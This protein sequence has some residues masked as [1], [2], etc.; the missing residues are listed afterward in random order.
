MS[1]DF[2]EL[3]NRFSIQDDVETEHAF[4][5]T[6]VPSVAPEAYLNVI[7]KAALQEV[8][9]E[10]ATILLLPPSLVSFYSQWN[11]AHLFINCLHIYGCVPQGQLLNR[12]A[13]FSLPPFSIET[14]NNG[15]ARKLEA[16]NLVCLGSYGYDRSLVCVDRRSLETVCFKGNDFTVKRRVWEGVEQWVVSEIQRIG[17]FFDYAGN[18]L[19]DERQLLPE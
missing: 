2:L 12:T 10:I 3:L 6:R 9:Q 16:Q 13:R 14:A 17:A 1:V 5:R 4:Y 19:V 7:F 15:L 18:C 8:R 11:G